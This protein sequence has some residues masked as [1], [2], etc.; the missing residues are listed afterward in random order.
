MIKDNSYLEICKNF[1]LKGEYREHFVQTTG[2]INDTFLV[3]CNQN[4]NYILQK[5]NKNVFTTP[6]LLI[7]NM[8]TVTEHIRKKLTLQK[9]NE[10][11]RKVVTLYPNI[12]GGYFYLDA[13]NNYWRAMHYIENTKTYNFPNSTKLVY[14]CSKAFGEF[15]KQLLDIEIDSVED[16]IPDFHN[17]KKRFASFKAA[18]EKDTVSRVKFCK[19]EIDFIISN[20]NTFDAV[21]LLIKEKSLPVR[22][23][24]NDT[25]INNVLI[26]VETDEAVCVIDLD[27]VMKGS[28]LFD[29][30]DMV[31]TA[32]SHS[33]EDEKDLSK[34]FLDINYFEALVS[35]YSASVAEFLNNCEKENLVF[36]A[37]LITLVIGMRFL[38]DYILGDTY[39][40]IKYEH[41]NF[42]RAKVQ[43]QIVRSI[44]QQ[45]EKMK[46]II[47][48]H[49]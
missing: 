12:D 6:E 15:Q 30:G 37:K 24:H 36:S 18:V 31:R 22:I 45:E 43:F 20:S 28:V 19:N 41:Q 38:T 7:N 14:N 21:P 2:H 8:V 23:T 1:K 46:K 29:F 44:M 40:K 49:F 27:T 32:T 34:V 42:D 26:D 3:K 5:I 33:D 11:L 13:D 48:N 9:E 35:G 4:Q 25:K 17:G 16:V 47:S 39:F 10:I